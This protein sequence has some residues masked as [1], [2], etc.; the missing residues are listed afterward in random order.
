MTSRPLPSFRCWT[1]PLMKR[2]ALVQFFTWSALYTMWVFTTPVVAQ[3]FYGTT[4]SASAAFQDAGNYNIIVRSS[5]RLNIDGVTIRGGWDGINMHDSRDVTIANST[6]G[7]MDA[8]AV[9]RCIAAVTK[10]L[11]LDGEFYVSWPES[12][13][14]FEFL[15]RVTEASGATVTRIDA[16]PHPR[17]DS[18]AAITRRD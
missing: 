13:H 12:A 17:G 14:S 15:Q 5:E 18:V 1:P 3:D 7:R 11:T 10:K 4:D 2:L 6:F 8:A 9:G 16:P